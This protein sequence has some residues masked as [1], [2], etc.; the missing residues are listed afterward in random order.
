MTSK[1]CLGSPAKA[2]SWSHYCISRAVV[3]HL[4]LLFSPP[5]YF[6]VLSFPHISWIESSQ[7][8]PSIV[9]VVLATCWAHYWFPE[10]ACLLLGDWAPAPKPFVFPPQRSISELQ[11]I[12]RHLDYIFI[13]RSGARSQPPSLLGRVTFSLPSLFPITVTTADEMAVQ[14]RD[15]SF[16]QL[17]LMKRHREKD[18]CA[19]PRCVCNIGTGTIELNVLVPTKPLFLAFSRCFSCMWSTLISQIQM[20]FKLADSLNVHD[21]EGLSNDLDLCFQFDLA[22]DFHLKSAGLATG[23][24]CH[25]SSWEESVKMDAFLVNAWLHIYTVR[26]IHSWELLMQSPS[27][28]YWAAPMEHLA[29][30]CLSRRYIT[31][32][33]GGNGESHLFNYNRP[34]SALYVKIS[35]S[36]DAFI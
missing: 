6:Q 18:N 21:E 32:R 9:Y 4:F 20:V 3:L 30:K 29:V 34:W 26:H 33:S 5:F 1:N 10:V 19:V 17:F 28:G 8:H 36:F 12:L 14:H 15:L 23:S 35:N 7:C 27:S 25:Y 31:G 16:G 13:F 2:I 24:M 22:L 11:I